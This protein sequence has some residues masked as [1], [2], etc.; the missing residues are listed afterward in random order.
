M[1]RIYSTFYTIPL[2][3]LY[4]PY[5]L[6]KINSCINGACDWILVHYRLHCQCVPV[7]ILFQVTLHYS[8]DCRDHLWVWK[9]LCWEMC[10]SNTAKLISLHIPRRKAAKAGTAQLPTWQSGWNFLGKQ[11]NSFISILNI[12]HLLRLLKMVPINIISFSN[13]DLGQQLDWYTSSSSHNKQL[14]ISDKHFLS[15]IKLIKKNNLLK[16]HSCINIF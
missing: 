13:E 11:G 4:F 9:P 3:F 2:T 7:V 15:A 10:C 14:Q 5:S 6:T 16:V 12:G 1:Y 8:Q